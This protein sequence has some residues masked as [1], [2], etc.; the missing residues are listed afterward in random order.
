[1]V[2]C[3][4]FAEQ[5]E[6]DPDRGGRSFRALSRDDGREYGRG[7][8]LRGCSRD[9]PYLGINAQFWGFCRLP[10]REVERSGVYSKI[11][12]YPVDHGLRTI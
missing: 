3:G 8:A 4:D 11:R 9:W 6:N 1:M 5:V 2:R 10:G 7:H 12:D